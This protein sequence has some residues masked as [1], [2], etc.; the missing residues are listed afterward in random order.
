MGR[1]NAQHDYL[2]YLTMYS[3]CPRVSYSPDWALD[4]VSLS[5]R[6]FGD[7]SE[8]NFANDAFSYMST[9]IQQL[10]VKSPRHPLNWHFTEWSSRP[11]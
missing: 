4:Y 10:K 11:P 7:K 2:L 9:V 6:G 3:F 1:V 5:L 8:S